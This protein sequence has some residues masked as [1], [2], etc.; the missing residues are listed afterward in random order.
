[1]VGIL[2]R[3][4]LNIPLRLTITNVKDGR[5]EGNILITIGGEGVSLRSWYSICIDTDLS[6]NEDWQEIGSMQLEAKY[7]V[8]IRG[9]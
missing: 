9:E 2:A 7:N 8:S 1:M 4:N 5:D 6:P 3:N